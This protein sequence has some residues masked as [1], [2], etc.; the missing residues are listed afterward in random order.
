[1]EPK[2]FHLSSAYP[3]PFNNQVRIN[4]YIGQ[5]SE[6][7]IH[8][9]NTIGEEVKLITKGILHS[10]NYDEQIDMTGKSSGVYFIS[11][12]AVKGNN[13]IYSKTEKISLIK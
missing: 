4:Y 3:N 6:V 2:D 5:E 12:R 13:I 1:M 10:G 8:I 7:T 11:L 9:T